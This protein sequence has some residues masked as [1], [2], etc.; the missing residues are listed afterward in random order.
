MS[1]AENINFQTKRLLGIPMEKAPIVFLPIAIC[2]VIC[3][4]FCSPLQ[5]ILVIPLIVGASVLYL[6]LMAVHK[7][8]AKIHSK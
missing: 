4:M 3:V 5:L 6:R 8:G 2:Y 7:Y 1:E